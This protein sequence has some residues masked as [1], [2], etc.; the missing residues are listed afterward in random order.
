[1]NIFL[2]SEIKKAAKFLFLYCLSLIILIFLFKEYTQRILLIDL[3]NNQKKLEALEETNSALSKKLI[4][5]QKTSIKL[6]NKINEIEDSLKAKIKEF[7]PISFKLLKLKEKIEK[8][9][10]FINELNIFENVP[11]KLTYYSKKNIKTLKQLI[12]DLIVINEKMPFNK[13][14]FFTSLKILFGIK[15]KRPAELLKQGLLKEAIEEVKKWENPP[16]KW[17]DDVVDRLNL[18]SEFLKFEA[19][20]LLNQKDQC[21]CQPSYKPNPL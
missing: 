4:D 12:N 16:K 19:T 17:L 13:S 11:E 5:L 8:G 6:E 20:I 10:P 15:A 3:T 1:M 18:E 9:E 21:V 14:N 2:K 7:T